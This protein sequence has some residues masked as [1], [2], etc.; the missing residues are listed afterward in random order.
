MKTIGLYLVC[1]FFI[2]GC[3][4]NLKGDLLIENVNVINVK[5]G[6]ISTNKDVLIIGDSIANI[7]EH[8]RINFVAPEIIDGKN[9]YLIPGLWDMHAH[10]IDAYE[11]FFPML[12]AN[13][14]TGIRDMWGNFPVLSNV[15]NKIDNGSLIGPDILSAGFLVEGAN[16][17]HSGASNI[18]D[19]PEKGREI[20][21]TQKE[22]GADFIKVYSGLEREVYFAIADECKKQ[23]IPMVG[24]IPQ[25]ITVEEAIKANQL[26][27]EHFYQVKGFLHPQ[28]ENYIKKLKG[29]NVALE[30]QDNIKEYSEYIGIG[31]LDV[32][33]DNL[34]KKRLT[35]LIELLKNSNSFITPTLVV[36]KGFFRKYDSDFNPTTLNSYMPDYAI[37]DYYVQD[38][39]KTKRDSAVYNWS[40]KQY[41]LNV[42]LLK[43]M[44][45]GGVKFLAGTDYVMEFCYPGFSLH[46]ELRIY[47]EEGNITP[48]QALQ[49]ATINPAVF[50]QMEDKIGTVEQSKRASLLL[51]NKNPLENIRHT[52]NIEGLILR[53]KYYSNELLKHGLDELAT[54]SKK[55]QIRKI[56]DSIIKQEGIDKAIERYIDLKRDAPNSYNFHQRQLVTLGHYLLNSGQTQDAIMIFKLNTKMFPK[57]SHS[58]NGLGDAYLEAGQKAKAITAWEKANELGGYTTYTKLKKIKSEN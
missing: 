11:H 9:K 28:Y 2:C 32:D 4:Q 10:W 25:K 49:T 36:D 17:T 35:K 8:D 53:G 51:L 21:R 52:K 37:V 50:L 24:H 47:V 6:K 30:L 14:V 41:Q 56:V 48:L 46:D 58:Y 54:L 39:L 16:P 27:F 13:G 33:I 34:E 55:P 26:S 19:T 22:A 43:P 20:V 29:E 23:N 18:A 38:S 40:K 3:K 15:K 31:A 57:L 42:D 12:L 7:E 1:I 5:T 45:E 44:V